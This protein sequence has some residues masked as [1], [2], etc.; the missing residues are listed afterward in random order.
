MADTACSRCSMPVHG[1]T[2]EE[3][4]AL[5]TYHREI[6]AAMD[7]DAQAKVHRTRAAVALLEARDAYAVWKARH[8]A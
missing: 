7:L 6:H 3:Q 5:D 1:E 4:A 8:Q 2:P